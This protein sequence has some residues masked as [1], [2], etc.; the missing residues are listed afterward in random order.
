VC[1]VLIATV[2]L[3]FA[4]SLSAQT[5][6]VASDTARA[7]PGEFEFAGATLSVSMDSMTGRQ[8]CS[9]T[10]INNGAWVAVSGGRTAMITTMRNRNVDYDRPAFLRIGEAPPFR[11]GVSR[12]PH[13]LLVPFH[14]APEVVRA[15][16]TQQRVRLRF[17][18]WPDGA[19]FDEELEPGDFAAAYDRGVELC[20]WPK[21]PVAAVHPPVAASAVPK[22][23]QEEASYALE[24]KNSQ[25]EQLR[26]F[27]SSV[28]H[29]LRHNW[30]ALAF[31]AWSRTPG[32]SAHCV[33]SFTVAQDRAVTDARLSESS[34]DPAADDFAQRAV[35]ALGS[36][37]I[38]FPA[39]RAEPITVHAEFDWPS[40]SVK[41][42]L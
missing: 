27:V 28:E 20:A 16:Y 41:I 2:A 30:I 5:R 13:F 37:L 10:T 17:T 38:W 15:L 4:S 23:S 29:E 34:G 21:L 14:R 42:T 24:V 39:G 3:I 22:E 12:R 40:A 19:N 11:L 8:V 31:P 9:V 26:R 35:L 36:S 6:P 32:V 7:E 1:P 33:M 18:E 25:A